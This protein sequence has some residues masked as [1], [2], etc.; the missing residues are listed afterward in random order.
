MPAFLADRRPDARASFE[1]ETGGRAPSGNDLIDNARLAAEFG[2]PLRPYRERALQ[3]INEVRRD[4][5]KPT[6]G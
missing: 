6:V 3:I 4:N 5:G 1:K 2:V